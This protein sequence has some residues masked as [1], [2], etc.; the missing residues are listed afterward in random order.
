MPHSGEEGLVSGDWRDEKL[1]MGSVRLDEGI[2]F[3]WAVDLDEDDARTR[4]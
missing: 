4:G 3:V 1:G 2:E